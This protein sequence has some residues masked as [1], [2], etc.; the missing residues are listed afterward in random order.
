MRHPY[1]AARLRHA[2]RSVRSCRALLAEVYAYDPAI[3]TESAMDLVCAC[4]QLHYWRNAW[5]GMD[6]DAAMADAKAKVGL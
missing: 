3:A 2:I 6:A 1:Y 5:R 4:R